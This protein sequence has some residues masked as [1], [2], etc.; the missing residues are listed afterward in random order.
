MSSQ[1]L[2]FL[3]K[4]ECDVRDVEVA[5]AI[6]LGKTTIE[7]VAFRVPRVKVRV[8]LILESEKLIIIINFIIGYF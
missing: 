6:R 8:T 3:P 4:A 7:P 5:R 1:G 2:C